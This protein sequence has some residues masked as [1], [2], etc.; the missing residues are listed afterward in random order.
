MSTILAWSYLPPPF[1]VVNINVAA[2]SSP[3]CKVGDTIAM[4][5]M[6]REKV[7]SFGYVQIYVDYSNDLVLQRL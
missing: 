1:F 7:S 5:L 4:K 2:L 6:I 3:Q